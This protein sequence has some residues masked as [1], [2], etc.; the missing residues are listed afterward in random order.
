MN[1]APTDK[2]LEANVLTQ[3][4]KEPFEVLEKKSKETETNHISRLFKLRENDIDWK[5]K[6]RPYFG[7]ALILLFIAQ[8]AVVFGLVVAAFINGTME[9]L[10]VVLG[11]IVTG[12]L[13]ETAIGVNVI[14]KWLFSD[15]DYQKK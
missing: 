1:E 2:K 6:K 12:T 13:A 7:W 3:F 15:I 8:N 9:S 10:E 14:I 11:I 4:E 5:V